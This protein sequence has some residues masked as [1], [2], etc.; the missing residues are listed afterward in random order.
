MKTPVC[1]LVLGFALLWQIPLGSTADP[2]EKGRQAILRLHARE[3]EGHLTGNAELVTSDLG[4]NL[5]VAENGQVE[6]KTR[7]DVLNGFSSYLKTVKYSSW[8]DVSEPVVR[9]SEDGRMGWAAIQ[10]KAQYLGKTRTPTF[11]S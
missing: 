3:R 9:V 11:P 7:Q 8:D 6:T 2:Q 4:E 5:N 10:I 1:C